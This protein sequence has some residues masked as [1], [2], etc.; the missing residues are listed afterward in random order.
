MGVNRVVVVR[1][2]NDEVVEADDV[3]DADFRPP[4]RIHDNVSKSKPFG[5]SEASARM[6]SGSSNVRAGSDAD[7]VGADV[8]FVASANIVIVVRCESFFIRWPIN[9]FLLLTFCERCENVFWN[10]FQRKALTQVYIET[11]NSG[12]WVFSNNP[13]FLSLLVP[14]A[15]AQRDRGG[16]ENEFRL[17]FPTQSKESDVCFGCDRTLL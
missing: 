14:G 15:L 3:W 8:A 16:R 5:S 4:Q 12:I 6:S 1:D 11:Q 2:R 9:L 10:S 13:K 7:A 17:A